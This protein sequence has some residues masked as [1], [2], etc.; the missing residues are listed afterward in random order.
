MKN[1]KNMICNKLKD[2]LPEGW[3]EKFVHRDCDQANYEF[4]MFEIDGENKILV[5]NPDTDDIMEYY[6]DDFDGK[7]SISGFIESMGYKEQDRRKYYIDRDYNL[8]T[9]DKLMKN[10][11]CSKLLHR[12]NYPRQGVYVITPTRGVD[13]LSFSIHR[14]IA[15]VFVPTKSNEFTIVNHKDSIH[16]NFLKENLE[17]C[18]TEYNNSVKN[19]KPFEFIKSYKRL[20]DNK[21]FSPKELKEEY[22]YDQVTKLIR[23]AVKFKTTYKGSNWEII[24]IALDDYLSAHPIDPTGWYDDNGLHDFGKHKVRANVCGVLE[25]DGMLTVG[26][27]RDNQC[28]YTI[29]INKK[30]YLVHRLIYEIVSKKLI[31]ENNVIDHIIPSDTKDIDNSY[32]N[33]REVTQKENMQNPITR[34][35]LSSE[36]CVFDLLGNFI[37]IV[38]SGIEA[39]TKYETCESLVSRS[40]SG[41]LVKA[42][43]YIFISPGTSVKERT[44]WLYYKMSSSGEIIACE[45]IFGSALFEK[46]PDKRRL[47][48]IRKYLNTGMPAPD[49]FYYQQGDPQNMIYDPNNKELIKKRPELNWKDRNKNREDN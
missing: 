19:K 21:V 22:S 15:Y 28:V 46:L 48:E 44:D 29:T 8:Y 39:A 33:L 32:N 3:R 43:K 16:E 34:S 23:R 6:Y 37:E 1:T 35:T 20:S 38:G 27:K 11:L 13:V 10:L 31:Q 9:N 41:K 18:D 7:I 47:L 17:W 4:A 30:A 25:V 36:V 40:R 12:D 45:I 49:G 2:K 24:D 42:G 14:L 5:R 26:H